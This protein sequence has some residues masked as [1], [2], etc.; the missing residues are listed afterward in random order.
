MWAGNWTSAGH[1]FSDEIPR[2]TRLRVFKWDVSFQMES[3]ILALGSQ[4][5]LRILWGRISEMETHVEVSVLIARPGVVIFKWDFTAYEDVWHES[6]IFRSTS[7]SRHA[8]RGIKDWDQTEVKR[9]R[10]SIKICLLAQSFRQFHWIGVLAWKIM[11][12]GATKDFGGKWGMKAVPG[13]ELQQLVLLSATLYKVAESDNVRRGKSGSGFTMTDRSQPFHFLDTESKFCC[14]AL[15]SE[16]SCRLWP[17]VLL[18]LP[19]PQQFFSCDKVLCLS[20][21]NVKSCAEVSTNVTPCLVPLDTAC[22]RDVLHLRLSPVFV[23][24]CFLK[25]CRRKGVASCDPL[26]PPTP[27]LTPPPYKVPHRSDANVQHFWNLL[28]SY[29]FVPRFSYL[30]HC[31]PFVVLRKFSTEVNF[32]VPPEILQTFREFLPP[33]GDSNISQKLSLFCQPLKILRRGPLVGAF[34]PSQNTKLNQY[35]WSDISSNTIRTTSS[36]D[37]N[38]LI[39]KMLKKQGTLDSVKSMDAGW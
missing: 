32:Q 36:R 24:W 2:F 22:C 31:F 35:P 11:I 29:F 37:M 9:G 19:A 34:E 6:D 7:N 15:F 10:R 38:I 14:N 20:T 28:G 12:S 5:R 18:C 21:N 25:S 4:K 1:L 30:E 3:L 16:Q 27:E 13:M 23:L 39:L 17:S 26:P 33:R 8:F